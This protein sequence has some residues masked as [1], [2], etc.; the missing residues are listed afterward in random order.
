[1]ETIKKHNEAFV[2]AGEGK[3]YE[4]SKYPALKTAIVSCMDTRLVAMLP[5]ALGIK[6]GDVK[7]I[8]NAGGLVSDPYGDSMRSLLVA[9]YELGVENVMIIAHTSCGVEGMKGDHFIADMEK[10][11]ILP[12][13]I[14]AIKASGVDL[15]K[16]LTGFE[17]TGKAVRESVELVRNH[18]LLPEGITVSGYIIDT[19][20]G[21]LK[22]VD[23]EAGHD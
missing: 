6:N 4:T 9:I 18:P 10:R 7:M 5:A 21:E 1:M 19:I 13:T 17:D 2:K 11:G 15:E 8:K 3:R 14:E 12:E 23:T 16:W 22:P 20:T